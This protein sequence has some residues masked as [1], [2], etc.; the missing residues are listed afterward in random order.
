MNHSR[1]VYFEIPAN[2][3]QRCMDFYQEVF[4]W[5]FSTLKAGVLWLTRTGPDELPGINGSITKK[6]ASKTTV[7]NTLNVKDI[8]ATRKAILAHGGKIVLPRTPLPGIG[9]LLYF[10]DPEGNLHGALQPDARAK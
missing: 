7:V 6:Q 2:D 3:P 1:I 10:I 9:W 4:G 8:E 5:E